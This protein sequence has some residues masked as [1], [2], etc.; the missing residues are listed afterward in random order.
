MQKNSITN[1]ASENSSSFNRKIRMIC[2][3]KFFIVLFLFAIGAGLVWPGEK[4]VAADGENLLLLTLPTILHKSDIQDQLSAVRNGNTLIV[5]STKYPSWR[6]DF[7][8][9]SG[10]PGGGLAIGL[11]IPADS[12]ESIVEPKPF[13]SC[14]SAVGLDNLEWRWREFGGSAGTRA[15]LGLNSEVTSFTL[16]E[17]TPQRIVFTLAGNWLGVSNFLRTTTITLDGFTTSVQALYSGTTGKDSM[18]WIISLF[19][20]DKIQ[21]NRV[22]VMDEDTPAVPLNFTSECIRPL[23]TGITIPYE[24]EFPLQLPKDTSIRLEVIHLAEPYGN[25]NNYEF[26]DQASALGDNYMFYPRWR[27]SFQNVVYPFEWSW[28]FTPVK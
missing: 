8:I 4:A 10:A 23:P 1:F 3:G 26:W 5:R 2:Q 22:T 25:P 24:F 20:P 21:A 18:W 13:R 12:L 27:G 28:R 9:G 11:Y 15:S 19:H 17:N 6:V 7:A 14:C 16:V